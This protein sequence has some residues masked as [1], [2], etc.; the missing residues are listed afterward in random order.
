MRERAERAAGEIITAEAGGG[1]LCN[2]AGAQSV[3]QKRMGAE[4]PETDGDVRDADAPGNF[5]GRILEHIP[6]NTGAAQI[7]RKLLNGFG[8]TQ[9]RFLARVNLFRIGA[10]R[11]HARDP[12]GLLIRARLLEVK[13]ARGAALAQ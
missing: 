5:P 8:E 13:D 9:A 4:K 10:G 6:Q 11:L 3:A 12:V 2:L 1:A 7:R